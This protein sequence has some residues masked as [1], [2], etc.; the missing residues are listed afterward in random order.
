MGL[1]D[2]LRGGIV[3]VRGG[4]PRTATAHTPLSV[5][6]AGSVDKSA[7]L[8]A[9]SLV[10]R[11]S[12][13][14]VNTK[15]VE[16]LTFQ[17][18]QD[19]DYHSLFRELLE[20]EKNDKTNYGIVVYL[21][22]FRSEQVIEKLRAVFRT[23]PTDEEIVTGKKFTLALYFDKDLNLS[24]GQTFFTES[25]YMIQSNGIP[26]RE[27]FETYEESEN[28]KLKQRFE[29]TAE[30]P[31]KFNV[32]FGGLLKD[33]GTTVEDCRVQAVKDLETDATNLHSF[34]LDDLDKA[35]KLNTDNLN[36]YLSG[37]GAQYNLE[38]R[39]DSPDFNP[40]LFQAIL[41]PANYPLGRYP[42]NTKY[43][44][45]LMQQVAV[46]LSIGYDNQ[47]MRSVNGPPGTG[48]TT[49][50]KDIFA[51]LVVQQAYEVA[52]TGGGEIKGG[53]ENAY[54]EKATI[55][56]LLPKVAENNIIVASLNNGAVQ[57]I[58]NEIPLIK[59]IDEK[60]VEELKTADYFRVIANSKLEAERQE[61]ED[62]KKQK[63]PKSSPNGEEKY[64][65]LFSLEG[66]RSGNV[67]NILAN[68]KHVVKYLNRV[69]VSS[70]EVYK[71]FL[72]QYQEVASLRRGPSRGPVDWNLS[73]E[74]LQ[75]SNPW[76]DEQFRIAQSR[77]FI[78]ALK[79]RKQFLYENREN[80]KKAAIITSKPGDYFEK[81]QQLPRIAF[82]WINFAVPVIS[83]TF[84][85]FARM[86]KYLG[87]NSLGH[88]F[89]DEAGQAPPQAGVG[90]IMRSKHVMVVGD[91]SQIKPVLTLDSKVLG[92]LCKHYGITEKYLSDSAS[93]QTLVDSASQ[94]GFY[95]ESDK[96][97][98]SWIGIPL[99][100]H[101]RC[102]YPMFTISNR[103]SYGGLMVQGNPGYGK[104]GWFDI[105]GK[106]INKYVEEQGE[107]LAQKIQAMMKENPAIADK[108][109]K[110]V[111]YVISPFANVAV[112]LAKKLSNIG[113]T[114]SAGDSE[115]ATNVGTIHTFQGKEAP[116]VF[117]VLGAD[118][119]SKGA[120][121]WAVGEPN[122]MNVA[123]TRAKKEF[124]V[125]GDKQLYLGLGPVASQT[126]ATIQEYARDHHELIDEDV[127]VVIPKVVESTDARE[128]KEQP[129]ET[130]EPKSHVIPDLNMETKLTKSVERPAPAVAAVGDDMALSWG[131]ACTSFGG[132]PEEFKD[133]K[134]VNQ[135]L[136]AKGY[137]SWKGGWVPTEK[138]L[139][140][141]IVQS[142]YEGKP[143][144]NYTKASFEAVLRIL[145]GE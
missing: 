60:L 111:I 79:V 126:H 1:F 72:K 39:S 87:E 22:I 67:K 12:E 21:G 55:G 43:A 145:T 124:Y 117:M 88:L 28:E 99:W 44:L 93:V 70:P 32:A 64:W 18:L 30:D 19:D 75:Q 100:V 137:I 13:G 89:V 108:N 47:Q 54:R 15:K 95:R 77:L 142:D 103:I 128:A 96:S 5:L 81:N 58:V 9:W 101:R 16:I 82:E 26:K 73:Y 10:E 57:N 102:Q 106:A 83:S 122:M 84:A 141:G 133:T 25:G 42:S 23:D 138:G 4:A 119:S 46:N 7:I 48:K 50:L 90:A 29:D 51:E 11:L 45:S 114:R 139:A 115:K 3:S 8:D 68:V 80:L 120:A 118:N 123:A 36:R 121:G 71:D 31:G 74:E 116:I 37:G 40:N 76:F 86:C 33:T 112:Q 91:P 6:Q 49:L 134:T 24:D 61:G 53:P 63:V 78:A 27:E 65:G 69:Y 2:T 98:E 125:I 132:V 20:K 85:S 38:A 104:T 136:K 92:M 140:I 34:F 105:S 127:S 17:E 52:K 129:T 113:F 109:E 144:C 62:G 130:P 143:T 14:D 110:D 35:R 59:D 107:F 135:L 56:N 94:Y 41:E 66:G 131:K 97:S